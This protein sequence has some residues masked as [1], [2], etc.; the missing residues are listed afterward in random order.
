MQPL[1]I[2]ILLSVL[3][4]SPSSWAEDDDDIDHD[5]GQDD[6]EVSDEYLHPYDDE[7]STLSGPEP[8]EHDLILQDTLVDFS[9]KELMGDAGSAAKQAVDAIAFHFF[10]EGRLEELFHNTKTPECRALIAEHFGYHVMAIAKEEPLPF[11][12][13][14]FENTCE[15]QRPYDFDNLPKGVHMGVRTMDIVAMSFHREQSL[16]YCLRLCA[17]FVNFL[18]ENISRLSKTE[19]TNRNGMKLP[20]TST[21]LHLMSKF[22]TAS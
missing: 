4:F 19:R 11:M 3:L 2:L 20:I 6:D 14:Q 16:N 7:T 5:D 10:N 22:A 15:D 1:L 21:F 9:S 13:I 18:C 17:L 8:T 12:D